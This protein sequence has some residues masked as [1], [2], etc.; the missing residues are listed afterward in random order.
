M[1]AILLNRSR[2]HASSALFGFSKSLEKEFRRER[3]IL[4][5]QRRRELRCTSRGIE[6]GA[7]LEGKGRPDKA[8][9]T[10]YEVRGRGDGK[11]LALPTGKG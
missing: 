6:T 1:L 2:T 10:I 4:E 11:G 3:S 5:P 9:G 8:Q 7:R